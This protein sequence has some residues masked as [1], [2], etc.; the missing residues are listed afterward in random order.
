MCIELRMHV[1]DIFTYLNIS[2]FFVICINMVQKREELVAFLAEQSQEAK[3]RREAERSDFLST[4]GMNPGSTYPLESPQDPA[5]E[6]RIKE[7]L[8]AALDEQVHIKKSYD[9]SNKTN[10]KEMDNFLLKYEN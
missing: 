9:N 7:S 6:Y 8:K 3:A 4:A 1:P 5:V 10:E 2:P